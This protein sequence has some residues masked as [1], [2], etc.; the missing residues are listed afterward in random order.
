MKP[1]LETVARLLLPAIA[2][3]TLSR[4]CADWPGWRGAAR[5]GFTRQALPAALNAPASPA[6][7]IPTGHGYAGA[8]VSGGTLVY[9]DDQGGSETAHA[10]DAGTGRERWRTPYAPA[11]SDEFEPGPRCTPLIDGDRVY[12]QSAQGRFACLDLKDGQSLW[13]F[14]FKDLGMTWQSDRQ[15]GVGAAVRRGHTGSPVIEGDRIFVQT[16]ATGGRSI[17]AL[18]KHT[19]KTLWQALD[20]HTSYSS[21]VIGTLAGR[22][23]FVTATCE[24]LVGLDVADGRLLWRTPFKTGANRNVLT[25]IVSGDEVVFASHTT[26]LRCQQISAKDGAFTSTERWF[27]R[28]VRINLPTPVR[29]GGHLYG[30]GNA[31]EYVCVDIATGEVRWTATGG[32]GEVAGTVA[33]GRRLLVL[34][35]SG[36]VRLLAANPDRLE[37]LGRFQA[38]GKTY[39]HPAWSDATLFVRDPASLTAWK[40]PS[41]P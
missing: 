7:K 25:P 6:W 11:W 26:G 35:D 33:D 15:G 27:N 13:G 19:G 36:E 16:G 1:S 23:Q 2:A 24:G 39:S 22:R 28:R 8:V 14:D 32:F 21:P 12:V 3:C 37:E 5:D 29:V 4:C 41:S 40:L 34:L 10:L 18:D 9:V 38:C 17:V 20:D 30:I 31:R